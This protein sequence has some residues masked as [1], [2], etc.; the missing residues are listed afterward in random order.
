MCELRKDSTTS[1]FSSPGTPKMYSTPSFSRAATSRS[2]PLVMVRSLSLGIR[3]TL[4]EV[5]VD[6]EF[7]GGGAAALILVRGINPEI[8]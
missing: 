4:R 8:G 1:R 6:V 2:E 3:S 5:W 7:V